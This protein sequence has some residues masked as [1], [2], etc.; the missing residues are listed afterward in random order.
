MEQFNF[1]TT[2]V[3]ISELNLDNEKL[4]QDIKQ[5]QEVYPSVDKSNIGGYQGN[6]YV[7]K[8]LYDS[9]LNNI[10]KRSDKEL[11]EVGIRSWVNI[12]RKGDKNRRHLHLDTSIILSGVYYVSVPENSGNIR[13]YDPRG[14]WV[15]EM[16][17]H[18]YFNDNYEY[19]YITPKEGLIL[20]F[21]S[22]L[23]HDV[24]ESQ[25]DEERISIG[26]NCCIDSC[27]IRNSVL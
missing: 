15:K 24:E 5:F 3:W 17:D 10:P 20:F 8:D 27:Q 4:K 23:E 9:I 7:N 22:W 14:A 11:G 2:P 25:S 16:I 6:D 1:F 18:H 12:N 21:P 13:F 26:F 19:H